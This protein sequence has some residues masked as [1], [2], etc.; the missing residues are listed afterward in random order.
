VTMTNNVTGTSVEPRDP[1]PRVK[2]IGRDGNAFAILGA[3]RVA[4]RKAG[5]PV[6]HVKAVTAEMMRGSYDDLLA[7]AMK[8]F[9][10]R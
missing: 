3:C 1:R 4:A 2:L 8:H 7:T 9:D 10:V 5:W 6:E